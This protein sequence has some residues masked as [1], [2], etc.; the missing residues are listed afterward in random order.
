MASLSLL[1]LELEWHGLVGSGHS[2]TPAGPGVLDLGSMS[3]T[4]T[5]PVSFCFTSS[6]RKLGFLLGW[7]GEV[8]LL[9]W[10]EERPG[11]GTKCFYMDT[12]PSFLFS[13]SPNPH[14][15]RYLG[16]LIPKSLWGSTAQASL[17]L[18]VSQRKLSRLLGG[19]SRLA[20]PFQLPLFCCFCFPF[21]LVC[22]CLK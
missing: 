1:P 18:S 5:E 7:G 9:L 12:Q 13:V 22:L 16:P 17:L 3:L 11:W 10:V 20:P 19:V 4:P 15:Q 21:T 14:F 6:K 8:A 2:R